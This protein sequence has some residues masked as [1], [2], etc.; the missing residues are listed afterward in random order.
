[1][2]AAAAIAI[3][4]LFFG[5][6]SGYSQP[7]ATASPRTVP[8]RPVPSE[9]PEIKTGP[10]ELYLTGLAR[11]GA[12]KLAFIRVEKPG[13]PTR[14]LTL[15]EG[16]SASGVDLVKIDADGAKATVRYGAR[17]Q[18]LALQS[19]GLT[20]RPPSLTEKEKDFSHSKHHTLRAKLDRERD[21]REAL[22]EQARAR[23]KSR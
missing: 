3:A 11:I 1:M 8:V 7:P 4:G 15:V 12:K 18:E 17:L 22:E 13:Q 20:Q 23:T 19:R 5:T 6:M 2:K 21:E 9:S 14:L 10:N 16:E